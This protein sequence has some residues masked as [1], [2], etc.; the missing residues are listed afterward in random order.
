MIGRAVRCKAWDADPCRTIGYRFGR[1]QL[2]SAASLDGLM[3]SGALDTATGMWYLLRVNSSPRAFRANTSL[4]VR[5][6]E[7]PR[8]SLVAD[9]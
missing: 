4:M 6:S 3:R 5:Y 9:G 7:A 1:G 8:C 2:T